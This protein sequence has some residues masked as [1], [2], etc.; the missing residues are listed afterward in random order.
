MM[1]KTIKTIALSIKSL[2]LLALAMAISTAYGNPKNNPA[3]RADEADNTRMVYTM[4]D[5]HNGLDY[6]FGS[7]TVSGCQE[8]T[9]EGFID[10]EFSALQIWLVKQQHTKRNIVLKNEAGEYFIAERDVKPEIEVEQ[11]ERIIQSNLKYPDFAAQ[12]GESGTV[13]VLFLVDEKGEISKVI[14]DISQK[15]RKISTCVSLREAARRSI[16]ATD[17]LWAPAM[18]NGQPVKKWMYVP[19]RFNLKG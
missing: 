19:V 16:M 15:Q 10:N 9:V 12:T 18:V 17:G 13:H 3:P 5:N 7:T 4:L 11:L 1:M 6:Y 2:L 8:V 14:T